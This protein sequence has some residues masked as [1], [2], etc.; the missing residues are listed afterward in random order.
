MS[1]QEIKTIGIAGAGTMGQ[2]IAQVCAVAGFEVLLYDIQ[3]DFISKGISL[4]EKSL[5]TA[6]E[7]GKIQLTEKEQALARIKAQPD[8]QQLKADL[9]IEAAIE[10]LDVKKKLFAS[11]EE[12]NNERCMLT[13][14]TSS[15]PVTQIAATLKHPERF[16]GLHFFNPA[17]I[18]KLVEIISGAGTNLATVELLKQFTEKLGKTS[19]LAK[20]S[21]GFIVN[22]VARHYYVE[23]LKLLEEN[24]SDIN[25]IDSLMKSAGFK[26]GPFELMDLI[27][28]DTNFSVTTSMY[29]AF[30]EEARFR[31]NR[32]QQQKVDAGHHGRKSGKGF[33]DYTKK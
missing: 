23:A 28:V 30:H 5:S 22:R 3:P 6:V 20:D 19:V 10:N 26:M 9:I 15:I 17:P 4:I 14:N 16:A 8:L 21:P 31:P 25:T 7:K 11:L 18:M 29:H 13:T 32:M 1:L 2:G 12:I 24:V 27:G 33:Y